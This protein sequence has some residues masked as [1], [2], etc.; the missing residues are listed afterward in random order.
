MEICKISIMDRMQT[1]GS[2]GLGAEGNREKLLHGHRI[3]LWGDG[4][5]LGRDGGCTT[6]RMY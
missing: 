3:L 2:K 1:G 4:S 6:L 5:V